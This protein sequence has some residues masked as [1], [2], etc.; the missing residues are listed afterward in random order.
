MFPFESLSTP[1]VYKIEHEE[2]SEKMLLSSFS[3]AGAQQICC[4]R[5]VLR[6]LSR[7]GEQVISCPMRTF[8]L[9]VH[10]DVHII[11]TTVCTSL[12]LYSETFLRPFGLSFQLGPMVIYYS[13]NAFKVVIFDVIGQKP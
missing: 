6:L 10:L 13:F 5:L 8:S 12:K 1:A 7:P 9:S 3:P 2:V 11:H 4:S